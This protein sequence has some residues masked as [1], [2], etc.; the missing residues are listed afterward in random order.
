MIGNVMGVI[1]VM[2]VMNCGKIYLFD[3]RACTNYAGICF[4]Q[5]F[6]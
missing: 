5:S 3:F 2:N 4:L 1:N 6:M